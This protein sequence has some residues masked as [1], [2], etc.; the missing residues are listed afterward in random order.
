MGRPTK[1]QAKYCTEIVEYFSQEPEFD[2][3]GKLT[4]A[5]IPTLISFSQ[6]IGVND[7]TL[8][9]WT[10]E[11]L[12]FRDAYKMAKKK[13]E[14]FFMKAGLNGLTNTA[15]T[16]FALKNLHDWSDKVEQKTSVQIDN[17]T[18]DDDE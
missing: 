7:G 10:Q 1:Y 12:A 17:I 18:F 6:K 14:E 11:N 13:Q 16:I 8:W 3:K 15:M 9:R 5:C 4:W 2:D